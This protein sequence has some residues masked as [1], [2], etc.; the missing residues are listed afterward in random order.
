MAIK[1]TVPDIGDF[2]N[3]EVI[4]ILAKPGDIIKKD[5]SVV[6]LESDKSSV[7]VPSPFAGKISSLKV[8]IGDKVSKG[9]VLAII[10]DEKVE[11]SKKTEKADKQKKEKIRPLILKEEKILPETEKIIKEAESAITQKLIKE[12]TIQEFEIK[13]ILSA[14]DSIFKIEKKKSKI[15]EKKDFADKDDV[16][17]LN[18]QAKTNKSEILVLD[19]MIE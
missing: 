16:L 7:E 2:K 18:N 15:V 11:I 4:E 17:T 5:D 12:P 8:K 19:Q 6:T 10:G 13:D 14:V 3:V 1:I 9:S